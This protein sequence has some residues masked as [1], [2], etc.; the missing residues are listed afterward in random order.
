MKILFQDKILLEEGVLVIFFNDKLSLLLPEDDQKKIIEKI[1]KKA[2]K[3]IDFKSN[4]TSII[5]L[6]APSNINYDRLVFL[7]LGDVESKTEYDWIKIGG[8]II[9]FSLKNNIYKINIIFE[10]AKKFTSTTKIPALIVY[11]A[12]MRDY[13]FL[14]YKT[15]LNTKNIETLCF[16]TTYSNTSVRMHD[17]LKHV[18]AGVNL[19]RDLVNEPS[20]VLYPEE[21]SKRIESLKR[22][23][24]KIKTLNRKKIEKEKMG[25]ILAVSQGSRFEPNVCVIEYNG[26]SNSKPIV[27]LG[28]GVTFDSGGVSIKPSGNMGEMK[29]DMAGSAAV[30]GLMRSIA[31]RKAKVNAIGIVGLVENMTDGNAM[32]PGDIITSMSGK[33][34]EVLNTDAEGRLVLADII[35]YA[36]KHYEPALMVDL[37]TLTGAI[38]VALGQQNAGLFSNDDDLSEKLIKSGM[39]TAETLWRMPLSDEYDKMINSKVA[40]MKN[41]GGRDSGSITAAQFIKRYVGDVPWAHIDIAGTSIESLKSDINTSWGSGYG[42]RLLDDFIK[43]NFEN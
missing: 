21:F 42:V 10:Y 19:A 12:Q 1:F 31:G 23:N 26:G 4:K 20:N 9:N 11:G 8:K 6:I 28:K 43:H 35:T 14:K 24:L 7:H 38:I 33:T 25:G 30:V 37:A 39:N 16:Q 17:E 29:G 5:D 2:I 3:S 36:R 13:N 32:R 34:V 22:F 40:D 18:L 27:F 41:I 15:A